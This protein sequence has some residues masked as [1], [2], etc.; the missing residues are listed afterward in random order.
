MVVVKIEWVKLPG[1]ALVKNHTIILVLCAI[2]WH[3]HFILC[4]FVWCVCSGMSRHMW[5][6]EAELL[7][8][9]LLPCV[10]SRD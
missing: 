8:S 3:H 10:G 4:V 1:I 7:E 9:A 2:V 6:S 5:R